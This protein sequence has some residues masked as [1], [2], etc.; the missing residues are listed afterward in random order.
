MEP[1]EVFAYAGHATAGK[2]GFS[3]VDERHLPRFGFSKMH[4]HRDVIHVEGNFAGMQA[5]VSKAGLRSF[6][7]YYKQ[8]VFQLQPFRSSEAGTSE[9][10]L[11]GFTSSLGR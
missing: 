11:K 1:V 4:R 9:P 5:I 10:R 8:A 7:Y 3:G 6:F 2:S